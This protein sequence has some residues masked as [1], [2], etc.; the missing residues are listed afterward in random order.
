ME[1]LPHDVLRIIIGFLDFS[2]RYGSLAQVSSMLNSLN[3]S[4]PILIL[5]LSNVTRFTER[6]FAWK[7]DFFG[8]L[9]MKFLRTSE[10]IVPIWKSEF[11]RF[12]MNERLPP[13][14]PINQKGKKKKAI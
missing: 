4:T 13:I 2:E 9:E 5:N 7:R 1:D 14:P 3:R 10:E 12:L 8:D 11:R 6:F